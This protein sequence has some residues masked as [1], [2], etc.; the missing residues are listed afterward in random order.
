MREPGISLDAAI[1]RLLAGAD[2]LAGGDEPGGSFGRVSLGRDLRAKVA[3]STSVRR[4]LNR[5]NMG[6]CP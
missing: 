2:L 4:S 1:A 3:V 6:I 5:S